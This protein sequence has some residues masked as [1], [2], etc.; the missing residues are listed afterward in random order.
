M[1]VGMIFFIGWLLFMALTVFAF[2]FWAWKEN[3]LLNIEEPKFAMLEDREPEEWPGRKPVAG[4]GI[5]DGD[6][7]QKRQG[8]KL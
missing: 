6:F 3:Q 1:T 8:D 2:F 7:D 5:K 4:R